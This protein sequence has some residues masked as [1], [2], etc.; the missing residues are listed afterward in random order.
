MEMLGRAVCGMRRRHEFRGWRA[1][2]L[3]SSGG[4]SLRRL[5]RLFSLLFTFASSD[6]VAIAPELLAEL[7]V[8][9]PWQRSFISRLNCILRMG[10]LSAILTMRWALLASRRDDRESISATKFCTRWSA[11][12]AKKKATPQPIRF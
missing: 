2:E 9:V 8:P 7:G 11:Q 4:A 5:P 6:L 1:R 12:R 10:G 3:P